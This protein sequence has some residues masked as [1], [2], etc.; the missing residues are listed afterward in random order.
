MKHL[1]LFLLGV[2]SL[3]SC[4]KNST[5]TKVEEKS[6]PTESLSLEQ[7]L[8]NNN[9]DKNHNSKIDPTEV[10]SI[11]ELNISG[12][13]LKDLKVLNLFTSLENLDASNNY[14]SEVEFPYQSQKLRKINLQNNQLVKLDISQCYNLES[15]NTT[16]NPGLQC[17]RSNNSQKEK[18]NWDIDTNTTLDPNCIGGKKPTQASSFEEYLV[19]NGYN[20]NKN[21]TIDSDEAD[22]IKELSLVGRKIK[23]LT[24]IEKLRNLEVLDLSNNELTEATIALESLSNLNI[25]GN[26]K[27]TKLDISGSIYLSLG[28][29]T[30]LNNPNLSCIKVNN[31]QVNLPKLKPNSFR[32][33]KHTTLSVIGCN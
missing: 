29:F 9:Y 13:K 7:W 33:D 4:T 14:L 5:E 3:V 2:G 32:I 25:S 1:F 10:N 17:I 12:Q 11:K 24:G 6:H 18:K 27:L 8:F 28:I 16:K 20:I 22:K 15:L 23:N 30:S 19:N 26:E 21:G 31:N